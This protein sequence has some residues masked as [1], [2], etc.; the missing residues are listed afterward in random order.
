VKP[1]LP[2]SIPMVATATMVERDM[3]V[4]LVLTSPDALSE[5]L[6]AGARLR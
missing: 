1:V 5:P 2:I 3:V 6:G 4:L